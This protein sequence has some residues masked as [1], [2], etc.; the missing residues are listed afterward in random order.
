MKTPLFVGP[1]GPRRRGIIRGLLIL[2]LL[3]S[4]GED[5]LPERFH[6]VF[7]PAP[8]LRA[9]LLG[10][11]RWRLEWYDP[12]GG[13]RSA[14][15]TG[16]EP[17][18]LNLLSQW[19]SPV[20]A[21]PHWPEKGLPPGLFP[22]AGA[23]FPFDAR[24]KTLTLSWRGG[25]EA[26]FYQELAEAQTLAGAD[27]RRHPRY[28]DW[29]RF[30]A[31][32][33]EEAAEELRADPWRAGWR[34]IAEKTALSGFRKSLVKTETR[35]ILELRIP[36]DGPWLS[37]SPFQEAA[38][39]NAGDPVSLALTPRPELYLS[40]GGILSLSSRGWVWKPWDHLEIDP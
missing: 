19:P 31:L 4:C 35:T 37:A 36:H 28:F 9:E 15:W 32:L 34:E 13:R 20:L 39:W 1:P 29:K 6:P 11:P 10:P 17:P 22:P 5:P 26:N 8:V 16:G 23:I 40:P 30:R 21:W 33:R 25:V 3:A 24:G 14:E 27:P 12:G 7:P 18:G 38:P 2:G